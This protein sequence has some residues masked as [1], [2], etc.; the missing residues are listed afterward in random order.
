MDKETRS[1]A[2]AA[3]LIL[4]GF[5]LVAFFMP[6]IMLAIGE[7]SPIAAGVVAI[8]FVA[9]FFLVFWLRGVR[10]GRRD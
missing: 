2:I 5:G 9:A 10:Q 8:V 3:A 6:S 4:G 7:V 1:A